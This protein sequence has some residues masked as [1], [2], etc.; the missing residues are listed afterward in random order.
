MMKRAAVVWLT[1]AASLVLIGSAVFTAA[2][3][4]LKWDFTALS[5][6]EYETNEYM[7]TEE[8]GSVSVSTDTADVKILPSEDGVCRVTVR[9]EKGLTHAVK[10]TDGTLSVEL[11]DTRKWYE[12]VGIGF[13][14]TSVT[15]Y[16]PEGAY[17][18]LSVQV[19]TGDAEIGS[20]FAFDRIE[21]DS[22]TGDVTVSSSATGDVRIKT[23]TGD[24]RITDAQVGA[25]TLTVSTGD[26]AVRDVS[27]AG[28]ID[29]ECST[30]KSVFERVGCESFTSVG[31]TGDLT[32]KGVVASGKL[33]IERSTGD[34]RFDGSDAAEILVNT[35]T[36]DV[37]GTLLTDKV[38]LVKTDTGDVRVPS[39][40]SGGRCE[41]VT[42]TGDV[43]VSTVR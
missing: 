18:D 36:G 15:V 1:V 23:S 34:V 30:G 20:G 40:V 32:L 38:F 16:L 24:I 25:L 28:G 37:E 26:I 41:I 2:M 27:C 11:Q 21:I 4:M 9:E 35:D 42:D 7:P 39:S 5:T 6:N 10:V 29:H 13:E 8:F 33:S 43:T 17:T 14:R 22:D 31:S 3:V 19:D 12:Y